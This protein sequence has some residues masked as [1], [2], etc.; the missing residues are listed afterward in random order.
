[1]W[2]IG[3]KTPKLAQ[4]EVHELRDLC[5]I[6]K[7]KNGDSCEAVLFLETDPENKSRGTKALQHEQARRATVCSELSGNESH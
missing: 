4:P 6:M 7:K 2:V 1:M 5:E 3:Q